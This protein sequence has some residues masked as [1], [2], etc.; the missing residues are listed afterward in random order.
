VAVISA[1]SPRIV[2]T[3]RDTGDDLVRFCRSLRAENV[4]PNTIL[5]YCGADKRL[6]DSGSQPT[7][8]PTSSRSAVTLYLGGS[9]RWAQPARRRRDRPERRIYSMGLRRTS[10]A[11][12]TAVVVPAAERRDSVP[13]PR[14]SCHTLR[15]ER[16]SLRP[17]MRMCEE[18]AP[19]GEHR[20]RIV[21]TGG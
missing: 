10:S 15:R 18:M 13:P 20:G 3:A 6:V 11:C 4:S 21:P 1:N 12:A 5:A 16:C 19:W 9:A 17:P 14:A 2:A 8:P 7:Y